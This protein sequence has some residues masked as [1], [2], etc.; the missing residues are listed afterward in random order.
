M[1]QNKGQASQGNSPKIS[2][3]EGSVYKR[4]TMNYLNSRTGQETAEE[5]S[6]GIVQSIN[7][8]IEIAN[9]VLSKTG[10]IHSLKAMPPYAIALTLLTCYRIRNVC[11][12]E[13]MQS[14]SDSDLLLCIY[15]EDG[16]DRGVYASNGRLLRELIY[17][18]N[19]VL[20][21]KGFE[22]VINYLQ[23]FAEIVYE[24]TDSDLIPL[25]NGIFNY[26]TKQLM[27]YT[28]DYVFLAKSDVEFHGK[29]QNPVI[30]MP[31]G[32]D[33]DVES[34]M[35]EI[36]GSDEI[37]YLL[38]QLAGSLLRPNVH[39][40]KAVFLYSDVGNNGKGTLCELFRNLIGK[41]RCSG[42][43]VSDF[44]KEFR[45]ADLVGKLAII[46]DENDVGTYIEKAANFKSV[47]TGDSLMINRKFQDAINFYFHGR[48]VQC[49]NE[50][51]RT[52]DKS[53]SFTRRL[54]LIPFHK[55]FTG[56]ERKYIKHEYMSRKD[57]LEY[58]VYKVLVEMPDYYEFDEPD[59]CKALLSE[60]KS[61]NDPIRD[62]W[63]EM[64]D[65]FVWDLLPYGFLYDLYKAWLE[66]NNPKGSTVSKRM[67]C[68]TLNSIVN[69]EHSMWKVS[70]WTVRVWKQMQDP[71]PLIAEYDLTEW[72][73]PGYHGTDINK[74][75]MPDL[76]ATYKGLVRY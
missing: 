13:N 32:L 76:K 72:M 33:W 58:V 9:A 62:F 42:L 53:D 65:E 5:L 71:E 70:D 45:L 10:R 43:Q 15:I 44:D 17:S 35:K 12:T 75:C 39:F 61:Y 63:N 22:E 47:V 54:L 30:Q 31:D 11:T 8:E 68:M 14:P 41:A 74:L 19:S 67:F 56:M 25:G 38:W 60:Y 7:M 57:V 34:W 73:N 52:K 40:D 4:G 66:K 69:T 20:S 6:E 2:M 21:K 24:T 37:A 3:Q 1:D 18:Y 64:K 55:S 28:P 48:I 36:S 29:V 26:K 46:A 23:T 16:P 49:V 59:V 50:L 27:D 51:P